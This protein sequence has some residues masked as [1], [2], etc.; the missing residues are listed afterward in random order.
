MKILVV[1]DNSD[2]IALL[3]IMLENEGF[4]VRLANNGEDGYSAYLRFEPDVVVTDIQMPI[5]TGIELIGLIR[6]HNPNVRTIYMSAE[7]TAFQSFLEEEQEKYGVSVLQKP[8]SRT[9]LMK[10][11]SQSCLP[12]EEKHDHP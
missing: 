12:K 5:K 6:S 10:S 3:K 4:D 2:F 7:L 8:F 9:E 11:I 1:D